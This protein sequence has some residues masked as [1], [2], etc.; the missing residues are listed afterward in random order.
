M[1]DSTSRPVPEVGPAQARRLIDRGALV[2]DV[3]EPDEF[4]AGHIAGAQLIPLG[5]LPQRLEVLPRDRAIVVACRSGRRSGEAVQLLL[6]HGFAEASNL[7]G[8]MLAWRAA[9]LPVEE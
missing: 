5:Q 1:T 4:Q 9:D 2:V 6:Q 3:R 7:A 8:G